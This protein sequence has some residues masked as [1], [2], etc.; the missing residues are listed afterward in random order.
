MPPSS[1]QAGMAAYRHGFSWR[2][3]AALALGALIGLAAALPYEA[4]SLSPIATRLGRPMWVLLAATTVQTLVLATAAAGVGLWLGPAVGLGAP[5]VHAWLAGDPAA[6][7]QLRRS[8][9]GAL[10]AGALVGVAIVGLDLAIFVPALPQEIRAA[11]MV[12]P[13]WWQGLLAALYGGIIE[14]LLLRLGLMTLLVS[15]GVM[16]TRARPPAAPVY[17][18]ANLVAALA[19]GGLHL[20]ATAAVIPLTPLIVVRAL[21]LNGPA[22]LVFGWL[23]WRRGLVAAMAAHFA[24]DVVL[25]VVPQALAGA[26]PGR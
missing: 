7:R 4:S 15:A 17:W 11:V 18:A 3:L 9:L 8:L 12:Q 22:G 21:A 25:H 20:P 6:G 24:A 1:T 2:V 5:L 14:E 19:F 10:L 26:F 16:L 23:Y 13:P